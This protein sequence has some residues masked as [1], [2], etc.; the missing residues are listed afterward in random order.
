MY[1]DIIVGSCGGTE[2]DGGMMIRC[3]LFCSNLIYWVIVSSGRCAQYSVRLRYNRYKMDNLNNY[4]YSTI[5]WII[6][7]VFIAS[8]HSSFEQL[9]GFTIVWPLRVNND[10]IIM[11]VHFWMLSISNEGFLLFRFQPAV[12][13]FHPVD[14][15]FYFR[16]I[17]KRNILYSSV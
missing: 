5:L 12:C 3:N 10:W 1:F 9:I 16:I 14:I 4:H 15:G 7:K 2:T 11:S 8:I 6:I 13:G 17:K